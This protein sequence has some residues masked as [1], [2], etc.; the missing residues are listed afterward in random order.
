M[1][2]ILFISLVIT[3]LILSG[4]V[5][6]SEAALLSV[7]RAKV[8]ELENSR[9]KKKQAKAKKLAKIKDDIQRYI[10]T[11][12]VL[13]NIINIIGSVYIGV[14]ASSIFGNTY[15]GVV[16]GVLTFLIIIFA[17]IIPKVYG[18]TYSKEISLFIAAPLIFLTNIFRPIIYV[19]NLIT[20]IFVRE[21]NGNNISEG[22]IREMA[23]LSHKEGS[24]N[25]FESEIISKVF[26]MNDTSAYDIMIPKSKARLVDPSLS[27]DE[28]IEFVESFGHTRY[29][30]S[31]DGEIKGFINVKDLFKF[32][33]KQDDFSI[34]KILRPLI[35]A[36]E[37]MKI[38]VLAEKF[39]LEKSHLALVVC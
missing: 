2:I 29:P 15:L 32:Y 3:I 16:S 36:P 8:K 4:I 6:S 31:Y 24:I 7:S 25:E 18:E 17:E 34:K 20:S 11:I 21:N 12:V 37:N 23:I 13:N 39:K 38:D 1:E 22:E 14:L 35:Y 5:S 27:F 28:V 10:S 33:D 26:N 9:N 19:I 30:V